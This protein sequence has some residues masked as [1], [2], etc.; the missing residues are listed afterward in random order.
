MQNNWHQVPS[1]CMQRRCYNSLSQF[2]CL[3][4]CCLQASRGDPPDVWAQLQQHLQGSAMARS[5]ALPQHSGEAAA[6]AAAEL[7]L[8]QPAAAA[9][10]AAANAVANQAAAPHVRHPRSPLAIIW[11]ALRGLAASAVKPC[12]ACVAVAA[13]VAAA[14]VAVLRRCGAVA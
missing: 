7:M 4:L 10:A 9:A 8:E 6:A 3:P 11:S 13:A 2:C 12:G 14:C 5:Q 1:A